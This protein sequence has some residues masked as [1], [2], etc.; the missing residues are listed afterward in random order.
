M[1]DNAMAG[2]FVQIAAICATPLVEQQGLLSIIRIQDRIHL[3][4]PTPTMQPQPLMN[5]WLVIVIKSGDITG[6]FTLQIVPITPSGRRLD[7]ATAP[8]LLE[9][10]ERGAMI[11]A[12]LGIV[13]EEEGLYWFE[14]TLDGVPLTR[15]PLRVLYQQLAPGMAFPPNLG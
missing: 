1:A 5:F 11:S 15:I 2:P 9:G 14:I 4:G 7:P 3:V 10:Q 12:P 8:V 13:A 6:K